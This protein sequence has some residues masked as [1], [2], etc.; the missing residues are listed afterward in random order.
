MKGT[1]LPHGPTEYWLPTFS[2]ICIFGADNPVAAI[3]TSNFIL[4]QALHMIMCI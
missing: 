4:T 3:T 1:L 2:T